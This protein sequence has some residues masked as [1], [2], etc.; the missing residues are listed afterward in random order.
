M[1]FKSITSLSQYQRWVKHSAVR[2]TESGQKQ[3]NFCPQNRRSGAVCIAL[4]R[5]AVR[6]GITSFVTATSSASEIQITYSRPIY[7]KI[8][9]KYSSVFC[10][11]WCK[12][13][14]YKARSD[15]LSLHLENRPTE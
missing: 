1:V 15:T 11:R 14:V 5:L 10:G 2:S 12:C 9:R 3:P 6:H 8:A 4:L 13:D 7:M